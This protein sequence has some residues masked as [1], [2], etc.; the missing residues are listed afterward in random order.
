MDSETLLHR[1]G[2][3]VDD[4][5]IRASAFVPDTR[6]IYLNRDNGSARMDFTQRLYLQ[7]PSGHL[8]VFGHGKMTDVVDGVDIGWVFQALLEPEEWVAKA[9]PPPQSLKPR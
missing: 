2:V 6:P 7:L 5:L 3:V 4:P 8:A 1:M 9:A